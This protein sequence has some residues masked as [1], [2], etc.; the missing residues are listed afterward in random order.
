MSLIDQKKKIESKSQKLTKLETEYS[1]LKNDPTKSEE[2]AKIRNDISQLKREIEE[3]KMQLEV[4]AAM[5]EYSQKKGDSRN[6]AVCSTLKDQVAIMLYSNLGSLIYTAS[7]YYSGRGTKED[8]E[9]AIQTALFE[10]IEKYDSQKNDNFCAYFYQTLRYAVLNA[11][12]KEYIDTQARKKGGQTDSEKKKSISSDESAEK[13]GRYKK[14]GQSVDTPRDSENEPSRPPI[15]DPAPT[16]YEQTC[17]RMTI[18]EFYTRMAACV[19]RISGRTGKPDRFFRAF[20]T[21][22]YIMLCREHLY[23]ILNINENEAFHDVMDVD[24]ADFTLI[25]KCRCFIA[26]EATP[27]KT[28]AEIG[29]HGEEELE[30]PFEPKVYNTYHNVSPARITQKRNEFNEK[31]GIKKHKEK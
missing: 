3:L 6:S 1:V 29:L 27:C 2:C 30:V 17:N 25:N 26:I 9:D 23:E 19:I 13:S 14:R 8:Y 20:A 16:P 31:L 5:I 11:L 28:Y 22:H 24:F 7:T 4:N 10:S 18:E 12:G 15:I 21:E